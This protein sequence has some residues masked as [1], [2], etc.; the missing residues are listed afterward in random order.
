[1]RYET[2]EGLVTII[3]ESDEDAKLLAPVYHALAKNSPSDVQLV[4]NNVDKIKKG[5]LQIEV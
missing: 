4:D 2:D 3:A 1:M 5:I